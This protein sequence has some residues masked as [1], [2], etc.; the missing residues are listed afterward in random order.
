MEPFIA[1]RLTNGEKDCITHGKIPHQRL[2]AKRARESLLLFKEIMDKHKAKFWLMYGT[3][4]GA[5]RDGDFIKWDRD[6]D[7]GSFESDAEKRWPAILELIDNGFNVLRTD[8]VGNTV[9][10]LREDTE[11]D[12][13]SYEPY[14]RR[15]HD[16][17]RW[18]R[19]VEPHDYFTGFEEIDFLGTKFLIPEKWEMFLRDHY[20]GDIWKT[21][22]PRCKHGK[23]YRI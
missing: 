22:N 8:P 18:S 20:K 9:Q 1:H 13:A 23:L 10:F 6:I 5:I 11:I 19:F 17:W 7:L 21:P 14:T 2:N 16:M 15:G 3:L 12:L 4:L